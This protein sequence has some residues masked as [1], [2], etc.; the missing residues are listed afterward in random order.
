MERIAYISGETVIYWN[1]IVLTLAAM[2]AICF[3]LAFYL[4]KTGNAAA[5]FAVVPVSLAL[6]LVFARFV[7]W[8]CRTDS[9]ASFQAAMSD[10][11]SGGY[12]LLG[13]FAGCLLAYGFCS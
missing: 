5:G 12:A 2:V 6:S 8:Y 10:Y 7:H 4:G 9:Y 13:V 11:T 3:F 1:S